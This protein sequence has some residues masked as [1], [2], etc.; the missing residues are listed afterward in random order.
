MRILKEYYYQI[1]EN[2]QAV[3]KN[4]SL[5]QKDVLIA[6]IAF[7]ILARLSEELIKKIW[8]RP[9]PKPQPAPPPSKSASLLAS[10]PPAPAP[11]NPQEIIREN[12]RLLSVLAESQ[13][14][15]RRVFGPSA[16]NEPLRLLL[17]AGI[18][19]PN[20]LC[21]AYAKTAMSQLFAHLKKIMEM[22]QAQNNVLVMHYVMWQGKTYEQV[23]REE[24]VRQDNAL[25]LDAFR[26]KIQMHYMQKEEELNKVI[27]GLQEETKRLRESWGRRDIDS[28][29][30]EE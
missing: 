10:P 9:R 16:P 17:G 19:D 27:R 18:N 12:N 4:F 21:P 13:G 14:L 15:M 7:A 1:A 28:K 20:G 8:P 22:L 23:M 26:A 6:C 2:A 3:H 30:A 25:S 24:Q 29:H 5:H 11:P